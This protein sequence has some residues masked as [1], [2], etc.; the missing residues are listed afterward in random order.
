MQIPFKLRMTHSSETLIPTRITCHF[1]AWVYLYECTA[2]QSDQLV[3]TVNRPCFLMYINAT[4]NH[5]QLCYHPVGSY[6]QDITASST[7]QIM[8][9]YYRNDWMVYRCQNCP[10]FEPLIS[11]YQNT[12]RETA[13]LPVFKLARVLFKSF[14]RLGESYEPSKERGYYLFVDNSINKY[15]R[16]L[17]FKQDMDHH[18]EQQAKAI[19]RFITDNFASELVEHMPSLAARFM[20]S[21]RHLARLAKS[22]FGIPLHSQV[23]KIRM[24]SGLNQLMTTDMPIHEI[25]RHSGYRDPCHFS[26]AFKK[27][28]QVSPRFI[29]WQENTA[30]TA[31]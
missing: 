2:G 24:N 12:A 22:A 21:E 15:Y 11:A 9:I 14:N 6:C 23:I 1:L 8:I 17:L 25:A 16:R 20:V 10:E 28:F 26:K 18:Y 4:S 7:N 5:C 19:A 27:C 31:S 30:I 3:F 29:G 13:T